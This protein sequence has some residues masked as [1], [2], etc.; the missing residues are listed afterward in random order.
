MQVTVY[1]LLCSD[2]TYYTGL[3]RKD[4]TEREWEHNSK[5]VDG[6]T[7]TRTPVKLMFT[8]AY[9]RVVDAIEREQQIKK[10]SRR[11][12]EALIR[13]DYTALPD[14]ASRPKRD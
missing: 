9:E 14:L 1:I 5:V 8:E 13:G 10:W 2:G 7:S 4:P 12:K 6:Y 11:K 3:T